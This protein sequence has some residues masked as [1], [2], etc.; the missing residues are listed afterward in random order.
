MNTSEALNWLENRPEVTSLRA[1]VCDLNGL[2]RG[3][4]MPVDQARKLLDGKMRL[5]L[6]AVC[7]D[8]WGRDVADNPLVFESGDADGICQH[9]GT[10]F[11]PL[12]WTGSPSAL[13]P[14]W[15]SHDDGRPYEGDPRRVLQLICQRY[16]A[17]GE[18]G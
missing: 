15:L 9:T 17:L 5:P 1:A 16:A 6:S 7:P 12:G 10:G 18:L 2:M 3:K 13:W 4:R 14:M 8:I 11:L